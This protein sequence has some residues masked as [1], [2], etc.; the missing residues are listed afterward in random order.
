MARR[1]APKHRLL[2][3]TPPAGESTLIAH[4]SPVEALSLPTRALHL[5][6]QLG[7]NTVGDVLRQDFTRSVR[8]FGPSTRESIAIAL[9]RHGFEAPASLRQEPANSSEISAVGSE[10]AALHAAVNRM[11][12]SFRNSLR[13]IER[14][15]AK[16]SG[17][18]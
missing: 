8:H 4:D 9:V 13:R 5:L 7:C 18:H 14:S 11:T 12:D 3:E 2:T 15:L 6:R 16:L 1:Q 10:V 17:G